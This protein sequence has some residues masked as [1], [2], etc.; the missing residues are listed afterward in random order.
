VWLDP[1][2]L[3]GINRSS[4]LSVFWT[5]CNNLFGF[6][7]VFWKNATEIKKKANRTCG[8]CRPG[9]TIVLLTW[10]N[11]RFMNF[12]QHYLTKHKQINP[13]ITSSEIP[14]SQ[15]K[16]PKIFIKTKLVRAYCWK[17]TRKT[18]SHKWT[19]FESNANHSCMV[20]LRGIISRTIRTRFPSIGDVLWNNI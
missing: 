16:S 4:G 10:H 5:V 1:Y 3:I 18:T 2:H 8:H 15:K 9:I 11:G 13:E 14:K 19:R 6:V 17:A 12:F 7:S 20:E